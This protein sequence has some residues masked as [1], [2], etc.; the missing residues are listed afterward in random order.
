MDENK[1]PIQT[2]R[3]LDL[4]RNHGKNGVLNYEFIHLT[5][6][7]FRY[8]ARIFELRDEGYHISTV[9]V[10]QGV[11]KFILNEIKEVP[12]CEGSTARQ[13]AFY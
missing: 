5:P 7:I 1:R 2:K 12:I 6:P 8:S 9:K 3:V 10:S 13:L 4:L 11:T